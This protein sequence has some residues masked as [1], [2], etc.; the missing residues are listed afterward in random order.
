LLNTASA[1]AALAAGDNTVAR[2]TDSLLLEGSPPRTLQARIE[3]FLCDAFPGAT[4]KIAVN[5]ISQSNQ[6]LSRYII[7]KFPVSVSTTATK[8]HLAHSTV[9]CSIGG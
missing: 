3:S 2:F 1:V 5:T 8:Y 7:T 4:F 6:R 9:N